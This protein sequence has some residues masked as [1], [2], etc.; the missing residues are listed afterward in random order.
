M[1]NKTTNPDV[2]YSSHVA[3]AVMRK[4]AWLAAAAL[5]LAACSKPEESPPQP[6]PSVAGDVLTFPGQKDPAGLRVVTVAAGGTQTLVVPG[7]LAWD[8]DHTARVYAPYAG[9]I[10]KL[11][12]A[13]GDNVKRGQPLADLASADIGQ[14]QADLH[15]SEAD[16]A[17]TRSAV[18][19]ARE[20]AQAG[21][22]AGKDL[23]QAEADHARA[24]AESA[25]TK[26]RLAQYGVAASSVTQAMSLTA[27]M[28][29]VLVE[30]NGNPGG[31]VRTDVQGPPLFTVSDPRTLWAVLDVDETQL[32]GFKPGDP[33]VLHCAAWP[34]IEFNAKVMSVGAS[35]D[36]SSRTVKVRAAVPNAQLRLKAEMFVSATAQ[37]PLTLPTVPVDAVYLR[38]DQNYIFVQ[39]GPGRFQRREVQVRSAGPQAWSVLRGVNSGERIVIG[40]GVYF[41]QLLDVA[42]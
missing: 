5:A 16:L 24:R 18:E 25:R 42:K 34:D 22:I 13:V 23:Q 35:V 4:A 17:L 2:A 12:V 7:R 6:E 11:R 8:E 41:N 29:G 38:G 10:D 31:E 37:L 9:R 15:K 14:A 20:L 40:T 27:P 1:M 30:R 21:V 32:A 39:T 28:A 3:Y 36:P 26:A 33:V 19:R